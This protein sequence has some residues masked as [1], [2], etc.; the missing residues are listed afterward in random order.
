M[1][2]MLGNRYFIAR[3]F[4]K[5]IP[6]LELALQSSPN[7]EKIKKKLI[8]CY[9]QVGKIDEAFNLFYEVVNRNPHLIT[10]TDLYYDDCPCSELLPLWERKKVQINQKSDLYE[11]LG[12]LYAYC[13]VNKAV[14]Y[15]KKIKSHPTNASK[16]RG[17]LRKLEPLTRQTR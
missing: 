2:E 5:A 14:Q 12:M 16:I 3:Q 15:L 13:N 10:D 4:D 1:S 9:I 11:I 7:S 8:I 17:V 6:P